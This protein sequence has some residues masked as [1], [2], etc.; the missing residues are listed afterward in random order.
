MLTR[1]RHITAVWTILLALL[2]PQIAAAYGA[3]SGKWMVMTICTGT[4]MVTLTID[5]DGNPVGEAQTET[6]PCLLGF[7]FTDFPPNPNGFTRF[8]APID[9]GQNEIAKNPDFRAAFHR[10]PPTRAPPFPV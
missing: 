1:I 4:E 3:V 7:E 5:A 6:K 8:N 10:T 9:A 2:L